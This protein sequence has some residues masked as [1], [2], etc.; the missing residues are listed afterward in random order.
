[1]RSIL[2]ALCK[3]LPTE[4]KNLLFKFSMPKRTWGS[5]SERLQPQGDVPSRYTYDPQ[6]SEGISYESHE[7]LVCRMNE[8]YGERVM[9]ATDVYKIKAKETNI[10][11]VSRWVNQL[12]SIDVNDIKYTIKR[13][14]IP[15]STVLY[16]VKNTKKK[17]EVVCGQIEEIFTTMVRRGESQD[18]RVWIEIN[19]Y[20]DLKAAHQKKHCLLDW[21]HAKMRL[22]YKKQKKIDLI[23]I[24]ELIGHVALWETPKDCFGIKESTLLVTDLSKKSCSTHIIL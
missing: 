11:P 6:K 12:N 10:L 20:D 3:S 8:I 2:P 21:P 16:Q 18:I 1:M 13:K 19:R 23:H 24:D 9:I 15:N 4:A 17:T 5:V 22:V 14:S 7:R